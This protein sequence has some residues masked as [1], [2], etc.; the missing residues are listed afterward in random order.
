MAEVQNPEFMAALQRIFSTRDEVK[1]LV[2]YQQQLYDA[3]R[4]LTN[5]HHMVHDHVRKLTDSHNRVQDDTNDLLRTR[6]E[7]VRAV[8]TLNDSNEHVR[9]DLRRTIVAVNSLQQEMRRI[10]IFESRLKRIEQDIQKLWQDDRT[11]DRKLKE[12]EQRITKVEHQRRH[13]L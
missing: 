13:M 4:E 1:K 2:D 7:I 5:S 10:S 11:D 12:Q 3:L 9:E 6:D 8:R